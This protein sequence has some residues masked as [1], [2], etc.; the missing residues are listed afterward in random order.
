MQ[1]R[2]SSAAWPT[3]IS[4]AIYLLWN[5]LSI[6]LAMV[7]KRAAYAFWTVALSLA[8]G[9]FMLQTYARKCFLQDAPYNSPQSN[10]RIDICGNPRRLQIFSWLWGDLTMTF[11]LVTLFG[12]NSCVDGGGGSKILHMGTCDLANLDQIWAWNASTVSGAVVVQSASQPGY[13]WDVLPSPYGQTGQPLY[14]ESCTTGST[15]QTFRFPP[16]TGAVLSHASCHPYRSAKATL[17][18]MEALLSRVP[19]ATC[20]PSWKGQG[21]CGSA[22]CL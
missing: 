9:R 8:A 20:A 13:C 14:L 18:P 17:L 5:C 7:C 21:L 1:L 15:S 11:G 4:F 22:E 10:Y 19:A 12:T 16:P 6:P 2:T 3:F